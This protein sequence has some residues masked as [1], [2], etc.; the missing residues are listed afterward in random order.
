MFQRESY[1]TDKNEIWYGCCAKKNYLQ[2]GTVQYPKTGND[3][4]ADEES[5]EVESTGGAFWWP[6][7]KQMSQAQQQLRVYH[8]Y[9]W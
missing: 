5:C 8:Y 2:I 6:N 7:S 9:Q 1:W 4:R 3:K